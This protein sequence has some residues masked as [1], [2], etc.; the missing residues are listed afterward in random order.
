[1]SDLIFQVPRPGH[2]DHEGHHDAGQDADAGLPPE[3]EGEEAKEEIA[4]GGPLPVVM[5]E[6]EDDDEDDRENY[7]AREHRAGR[8]AQG[9][10]IHHEGGEGTCNQSTA[11]R[12]AAPRAAWWSLSPT[13]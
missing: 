5:A 7:C 11:A 9:I 3:C 6:N 8:I 4:G 10:G 12:R 2:A 13:V 1:M